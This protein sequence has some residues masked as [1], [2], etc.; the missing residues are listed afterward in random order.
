MR[1]PL[2][3]VLPARRLTLERTVPGPDGLGILGTPSTFVIHSP[4]ETDLGAGQY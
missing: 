4:G 3:R 1:Q 2:R